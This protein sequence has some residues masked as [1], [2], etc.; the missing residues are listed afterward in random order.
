MMFDI[1]VKGECY[2]EC[3]VCA[4]TVTRKDGARQYQELRLRWAG[5]TDQDYS[6]GRYDGDER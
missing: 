2:D 6:T 3:A 4:I 5:A 1:W